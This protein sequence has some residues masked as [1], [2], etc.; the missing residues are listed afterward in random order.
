LTP[1]QVCDYGALVNEVARTLR[2]GGLFLSVEWSNHI[3]LHPSIPGDVETHAPAS[4][5]FYDTVNH[6]LATLGVNPDGFAAF[7]LIAN[8]SHFT[9]V[10]VE[11]IDVPIGTW[12]PEEGLR[13]IG[14]SFRAAQKRLAH[15]YKRMLLTAGMSPEAV[16][17]LI[18]DFV[19]D[20]YTTDGLMMTVYL[21]SAERV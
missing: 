6:N 15:A 21:T 14:S 8:S 13:Q 16:D 18:D 10:T 4:T 9:S 19:H 2:L 11:Q 1:F 7:N 5:H 3:S 20:L 17:T 12:H